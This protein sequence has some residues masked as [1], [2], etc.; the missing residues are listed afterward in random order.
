MYAPGVLR[1][2]N[3]SEALFIEICNLSFFSNL[4]RF[5]TKWQGAELEKN[6]GLLGRGVAIL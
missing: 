5:G 2:P 3:V 6:M 4:E 1:P